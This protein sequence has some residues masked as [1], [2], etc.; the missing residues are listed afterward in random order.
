M[1][2][3]RAIVKKNKSTNASSAPPP[4]TANENDFALQKQRTAPSRRRT[5]IKSIVNAIELHS[6]HINRPAIVGG[7]NGIQ[8]SHRA[9]AEDN[10]K[11]GGLVD[12]SLC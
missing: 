7:E 12:R 10:T 6:V 11:S 1:W 3:N 4:A 9:F 2:P 8:R 5:V